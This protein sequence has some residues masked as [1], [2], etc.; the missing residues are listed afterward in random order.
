[1]DCSEVN[2]YKYKKQT[3]LDFFMSVLTNN[4][5]Y[6]QPSGFKVIIDHKKYGNIQFFAQS[7]DHPSVSINAVDVPFKRANIHMAGDKLT[8]GPLTINA[9]IDEDINT[10]TEMFDWLKRLVEQNN[11]TQYNLTSDEYT[12]SV[13]ITVNILSSHNN[14]VKSIRYHDCVP[15]DI[16]SIN[17][18]S[19]TGDVQYLTFPVTFSF[20]YFEL[21]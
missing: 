12:T 15:I 16:G 7:V 21:V 18:Q 1:M 9:I 10:Y 8:F 11:K 3:F 19:T 20:S 6:L 5:N 17:F 14:K 2:R 4:I 13:D